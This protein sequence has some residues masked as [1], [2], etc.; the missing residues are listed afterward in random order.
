M[1][2]LIL[3]RLEISLSKFTLYITKFKNNLKKV[4]ANIRR[5]IKHIDLITNFKREMR[6]G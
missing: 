3:T 1:G 5:G 4:K 2:I 6:Y